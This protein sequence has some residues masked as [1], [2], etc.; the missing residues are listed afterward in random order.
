[1]KFKFENSLRTINYKLLAK[2]ERKITNFFVNALF[3]QFAKLTGSY[4]GIYP[5]TFLTKKQKSKQINYTWRQ[6]TVTLLRARTLIF[7]CA[8]IPVCYIIYNN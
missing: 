4:K 2:K 3:N 5:C 7:K 8:E 1:M 6:Q